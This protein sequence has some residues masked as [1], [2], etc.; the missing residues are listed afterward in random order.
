MK[1]IFIVLYKYQSFKF[2]YLIHYLKMYFNMYLALI[3]EITTVHN[4]LK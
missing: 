1:I 4:K 2:T 3:K